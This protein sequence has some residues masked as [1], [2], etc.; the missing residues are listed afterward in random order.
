MRTIIFMVSLFVV[1]RV[2]AQKISEK[3]VPAIVKSTLQK[4]FPHAQEVKWEK[5]KENYEAEFEI[6]ETNYSLL[7]GA[8]GHVIETEMEIKP[9]ELPTKAKEYISKHYAGQKIKEA[10]KITDSQNKITYEAEIK[11]KD[12]IFSNNGDFIKEKKD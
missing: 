11:G 9:E 6:K 1:S 8:S 4:N 12:L 2:Y 5:E 3:E 7:I 10:A